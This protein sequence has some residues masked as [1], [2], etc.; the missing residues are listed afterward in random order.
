[1]YSIYASKLDTF[2]HN[3]II[4]DFSTRVIHYNL[5]AQLEYWF[6]IM[7]ALWLQQNNTA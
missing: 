1:M 2:L 6:S 4:T 3:F 7:L 5:T